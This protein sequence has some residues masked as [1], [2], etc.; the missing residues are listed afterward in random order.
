MALVADL[1]KYN[2]AI[3]YGAAKYVK[4]LEFDKETGEVLEEKKRPCFD[5][6]KLAE[7]RIGTHFLICFIA[8]VIIRLIIKT[9]KPA[10]LG[11]KDHFVL[12]Q[13]FLL[14]RAG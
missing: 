4:N 1:I 5:S 7:D 2:K 14:Q 3:A 13:N 11:G 6:E 12:K 10:L 9:N 8:L